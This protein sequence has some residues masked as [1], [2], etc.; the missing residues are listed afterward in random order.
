[1]AAKMH[2]SDSQP[3]PDKSGWSSLA[4]IT[5]FDRGKTLNPKWRKEGH[6]LPKRVSAF[7]PSSVLVES[8][9][10]QLCKLFEKDPLSQKKLYGL[11]CKKLYEMK[12]IDKT[13]KIEE[14]Q[15]MRSYYQQALFH[16]LTVSNSPAIDCKLESFLNQSP[17]HLSLP[18][19][20]GS[21]IFDRSRYLDEFEEI[22]FIA[23]GGFGRVFRVR[24]KIDGCE[25]AIKKICLRY[26]GDEQFLRSLRE[27]RTLA[28]LDHCNIVAYKAAWF[29]PFTGMVSGENWSSS[30][31]SKISPDADP[32]Y[33]APESSSSPRDSRDAVEEDSG[34]IVFVNGQDGAC[35]PLGSH[36][37]SRPSGEG[38]GTQLS[39][40]DA[41]RPTRH[42]NM[43]RECSGSKVESVDDLAESHGSLCDHSSGSS[44]KGC[45]GRRVPGT[46][47]TLGWAVLH[48]Q[49]QLCKESLRTWLDSR[50]ECV[51]Q[52]KGG[53]LLPTDGV[54]VALRIFQGV[55]NGVEYMH[56][57]DVVHHDLKPSN[58]FVEG[59]EYAPSSVPDEA[60]SAT[61]RGRR[62]S[63]QQ[64]RVGDF[65]LACHLA[66][67]PS[68]IINN[69]PLQVPTEGEE[70]AMAVIPSDTP[71]AGS[72]L[73]A[74][75][76]LR[77][78][79]KAKEI[80]GTKLYAAP[81]Q[82]DGHCNLKSDMYSLA[83]ILFELLN[84]FFTGME[85]GKVI[86]A[87]RA[88]GTVPEE[89][90]RSHPVLASLIKEML[91]VDPSLRP[92]IRKIID[93]VQSVLRSYDF[94]VWRKRSESVCLD[95]GVCVRES[96]GVLES[97]TQEC[98]VRESCTWQMWEEVHC[99]EAE[100]TCCGSDACTALKEI[101]DE[102]I[103]RLREENKRKD[104]II[105]ELREK[106]RKLECLPS[107]PLS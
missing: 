15:F 33:E 107:N 67:P 105:E 78:D 87:L 42:G 101:Q 57:M 86:A 22:E 99:G 85:R 28:K 11:I 76:T 54:V 8:L 1:M 83:I 23:R 5:T 46:G 97:W 103:C 66:H 32:S 25:Y 92:P 44:N 96:G 74:I 79:K 53:A 89:F 100:A 2:E 19:A 4:T 31:S 52:V 47:C 51:L 26:H 29:E 64:V 95:E 9:V 94:G 50:N 3:L 84:P 70:G 18:P 68:V 104:G 65:G 81:E 7:T 21:G 75:A 43:S 17:S 56:G 39:S 35:G 59:F 34:H 20:V 37:N 24:N 80:V 63:N 106:I 77:E 91:S 45:R 60:T 90:G 58:I 13:Y 98:E 72:C 40:D 6:V 62:P 93:V 41:S 55:L 12:L 30:S 61:R 73:V 14:Y 69:G 71:T 16:L 27:V 10:E 38:D 82:L 49:M 48:I 88:S 102:T 36:S